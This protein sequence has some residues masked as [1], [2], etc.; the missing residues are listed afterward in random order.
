M[1]AIRMLT[2]SIRFSSLILSTSRLKH[3]FDKPQQALWPSF[4]NIR[5]VSQLGIRYVVDNIQLYVYLPYFWIVYG[6]QCSMCSLAGSATCKGVSFLP[7]GGGLKVA[8]ATENQRFAASC[9]LLAM[10]SRDCHLI[11]VL[12]RHRHLDRWALSVTAHIPALLV[13]PQARGRTR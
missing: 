5:A 7:S 10:H 11:D 3:S 6:V 13:L 12:S 2:S 1:L 4:D 8:P 9:V